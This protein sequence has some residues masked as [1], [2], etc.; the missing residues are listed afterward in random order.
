M[1]VDVSDFVEDFKSLMDLEGISLDDY[2]DDDLEL[3]LQTK[4]DELTAYTGLEINPTTHKEIKRDFSDDM[5]EVDFYPVSEISSF[6]IGSKTLT[7]DDYTLDEEKGILYFH[8]IMRGMLVLEYNSCLPETIFSSKVKPLLFDM[9]KYML[10]TQSTS[11][12]VVSS[13]KEG[14]VSVNYDTSSSLGNLILSRMNNL[15]SM[16]S[17]RIKVI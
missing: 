3:L 7:S 13:V 9:G 15:K 17:V 2:S 11:D 5:Y 8:S 10:T 14:D 12:G 4:L 1:S 6:T 16:Y